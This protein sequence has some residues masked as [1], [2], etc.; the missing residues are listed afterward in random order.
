MTD[1]RTPDASA[2]GEQQ[3][4]F[5]EAL[6]GVKSY[7]DKLNPRLRLAVGIG[8]GVAALGFIVNLV[9]VLSN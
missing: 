1:E 4:T 2:T 9:A 3:V 5:K 8:L 6:V 7:I